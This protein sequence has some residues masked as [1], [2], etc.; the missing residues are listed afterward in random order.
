MCADDLPFDTPRELFQSILN[1]RIVIRGAKTGSVLFALFARHAL[2]GAVAMTGLAVTASA[3]AAP[4]SAGDVLRQTAP[5]PALPTVP[6]PP[7]A[8][9]APA[10]QEEK[11]GVRIAVR[12]ITVVGN[13]LVPTADLAPLVAELRGRTVT[14]GELNQAA[15]RLTA[16]YRAHGYP[17]AYAYIPAQAITD[18]SVRIAVVEPRYDKVTLQGGSRLARAQAERTLG[19]EPG[20]A[21]EQ[22]P[23]ERGLLLLDQT[24]GVR[25]AGTLVPGAEAGTT[26]L[27]VQM[28]DTPRLRGAASVDNKG[29]EATGR[30]RGLGELRLDNPFG[31]GGQMA[32][33][34]LGTA[35]GLLR[36]GAVS[37]R[38]P[39][40][41]EGLRASLY[42]SRTD[43]SLG[44][45]FVSLDLDGQATQWGL[46]LDYP[47]IL[48]PGRAV[49]AR[50]D[51]LR[52]R[53]RQE[54]AR[55][56]LDDRSHVDLL[57]LTLN[58]AMAHGD[59]GTTSGGVSLA[60][61]RL[62]LDSADARAADASGPNAAGG[63]WVGQAE[64]QHSRPLPA[65]FRLQANVSGQVASR[66]LDGSQKFYVTGPNGVMSYQVGE[67]GGDA[68]VLLRLTLSH[69]IPLGLP[70]RLEAA[71]LGQHGEVWR[72]HAPAPG[73]T[74][75]NR[76]H[77]SGA[78]VGLQ[79]RWS[80]L[81]SQVEYVRRVGP[82]PAG[83]GP[84]PDQVWARL[85]VDF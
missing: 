59:G 9:P 60:R 65:D 26:S 80:V 44:G 79:Y 36:S 53:F 6:A 49:N 40:L 3:L 31:Y 38:S 16:F 63:F 46:A 72:D 73:A 64:L 10:Q 85:R 62:S 2:R 50:V 19:L 61:G 35:G 1:M 84:S 74:T 39:D 56:G 58:G 75:P 70:G 27:D 66:N 14:L 25:V 51:L 57:R 23:L 13:Q 48:R 76:V 20:A 45:A 33:S 4:P 5:P 28:T 82:A 8:L 42:G 43:Y 7:L 12:E 78:G 24:P 68:G 15:G 29:S 81:S 83:T 37:L 30:T 11:S 21:I 34:G 32:V 77:L 47:V 67:V 17:L 52:S 18:G 41:Y 69:D 22:A 55:I 71:L 54:S